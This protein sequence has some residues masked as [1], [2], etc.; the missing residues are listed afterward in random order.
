MQEPTL[1]VVLA[2]HDP[3]AHIYMQEPTLSLVLAE[4][5]PAAGTMQCTGNDTHV[6]SMSQGHK[7]ICSLVS[8]TCLVL[9]IVS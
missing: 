9:T 6:S 1:S 4:H 3:V 5:D 8:H 2:E 7:D